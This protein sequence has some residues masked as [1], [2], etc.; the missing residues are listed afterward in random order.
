MIDLIRRFFGAAVVV[1]KPGDMELPVHDV[2]VAACAL[3]LE[4]ANIDGEF[5]AAERTLFFSILKRDFGLAPEIA[6]QVA[7]EATGELQSSL[8]LWKFTH[9]I[10]ENYS[11]PEKLNVIEMLWKIV[12]ADDKLDRHEDYLVH[13]LAALLNIE[14]R[15]LITAKLKVLNERE[16]ADD[17]AAD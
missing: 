17:A 15:Q 14:H 3:F 12:F 13:K 5:N 1:G 6:E 10:N 16:S 2:R 4:M 9:L 8:D 7:A 11:L